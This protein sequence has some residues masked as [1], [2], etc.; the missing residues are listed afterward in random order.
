MKAVRRDDIPLDGGNVTELAV[1]MNHVCVLKENGDAY[2]WGRNNERQCSVDPIDY[3]Y[4]ITTPLKVNLTNITD[5]AAGY[6]FTC[7]VDVIHR[8]YCFGASKNNNK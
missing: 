6:A 4:V 3:G 7:V 8:M 2:C 1:G 5:I